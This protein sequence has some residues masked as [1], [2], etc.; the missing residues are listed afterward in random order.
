MKINSIN[1]VTSNYNKQGFKRTA[2]PYPEYN[3]AYTYNS[4]T[5]SV[6][7]SLVDKISELFHPSVTKEA[8]DIKQKID[9]IY[10]PQPNSPKAQLLSVLA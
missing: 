9:S 6:I 8:V 4:Q 10:D 5:E 3:K 2:V 1:N 7:N